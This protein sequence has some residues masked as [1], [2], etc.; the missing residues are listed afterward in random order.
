VALV[1]RAI[2]PNKGVRVVAIASAWGCL[3]HWRFSVE[4]SRWPGISD[5]FVSRLEPGQ[6]DLARVLG[7]WR[8][9]QQEPGTWAALAMITLSSI[10]TMP[11]LD[12]RGGASFVLA[13]II[14]RFV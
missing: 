12:P 11:H 5:G 4:C 2:V 14:A 9:R 7:R 1:K 6:G 3:E 8:E 10:A 13:M